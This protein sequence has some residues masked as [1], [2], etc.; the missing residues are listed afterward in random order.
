MK[1]T[2]FIVIIIVIVHSLI[3]VLFMIKAYA[4]RVSELKMMSAVMF[5]TPPVGVFVHIGQYLVRKLSRKPQEIPLGEVSFDKGRRGRLVEPDVEA[6]M[7]AV[8]LE[9]LFLISTHADKRKH[10]LGELKKESSV[11]FG[12]IAKALDNEDP[13]SA[14]YAAA[15]LASA[16]ADFENELREFDNQ[17][18]RKKE[19]EKLCR[20]YAGRVRAFLDSGILTG[21]ELKRYHYLIINLL[22]A[23]PGNGGSLGHDDYDKIVKSALFNNEYEVAKKWALE[24]QAENASETSYLNLLTVYYNTGLKEEFKK[25]LDDLKNS[26]FD[27]TEDGLDLVRFFIKPLKEGVV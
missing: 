19:D 15:A 14:H 11:N 20:D 16:K 26:D 21:I 6:E 8:P 18:N 1:L 13:E 2:L 5:L 4:S 7:Q 22:T 12:T 25:T 3:S 23:I 9:E 24:C 27:L 10:L 17:Y